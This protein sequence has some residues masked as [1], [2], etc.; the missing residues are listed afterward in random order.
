[1]KRN[2]TIAKVNQLIILTAQYRAARSK[3]RHSHSTAIANRADER[4]DRIW[5]KMDRLGAEIFA[6]AEAGD[7]VAEAYLSAEKKRRDEERSTAFNT[8]FNSL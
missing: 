1:M 6:L 8:Y 2:T 5:D 3:S 7:T 4:S